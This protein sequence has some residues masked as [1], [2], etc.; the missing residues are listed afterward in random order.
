MAHSH[1][2]R[3]FLKHP[4]RMGTLAQSSASLARKMAEQINGSAEVIEFGPGRGS[5]TVEILKRLPQNGRLICFE[6][7][8]EF[9][10]HLAKIQDPRLKIINDDAKNCR[11]YVRNIECVVSGLPL[12]IFPKAERDRIFDITSTAKRYIQLQYT[13]F[14]GAR[15]QTYFPHVKVKFVPINF[16]P[17]FVYVCTAP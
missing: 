17:A 11:Q 4:I 10:R 8:P 14:L 3:E 16:P 13:P 7:N 15:I 2:I 12:A 1:F 9:C 6:I 5:V